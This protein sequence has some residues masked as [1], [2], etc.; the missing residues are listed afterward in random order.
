MISTPTLWGPGAGTANV[1]AIGLPVTTKEFD[2]MHARHFSPAIVGRRYEDVMVVPGRRQV[3][4]NISIPVTPDA[5]GFWLLMTLG[6]D[7][8]TATTGNAGACVLNAGI[9]ANATSMVI[10]SL[11]NNLTA[12][13]RIFFRDTTTVG[14]IGTNPEYATV[15]ANATAGSSVTVTITGGAGTGG[16]VKNAHAISTLVEFG[17]WTHTFTPVN[18]PAGT[19]SFQVEDNEGGIAVSKFFTGMVVDSMDISAPIEKDGDPLVATI[20]AIGTSINPSGTQTNTVNTVASPN[21]AG[22]FTLP[23]EEVP[24]VPGNFATFTSGQTTK[25]DA[26]NLNPVTAGGVAGKVYV[27]D[28]KVTLSNKAQLAKAQNSSPDPYAAIF[29]NFSCKG[30]MESLFEDYSVFYD[31]VKTNV[32]PNSQLVVNWGVQNLTSTTGAVASTLTLNIFNFAMEKTGKA[33]SKSELVYFPID[34]WRAVDTSSVG[35]QNFTTLMSAVL[36]NNVAVY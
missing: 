8:V 30:T 6:A 2:P 35:T 12:G 19:P 26:T 7:A 4:A 23:T 14:G 15:A 1:N 22:A 20:K 32:W 5:F 28:F 24:V 31:Y 9:S 33:A 10:T 25:V 3:Q 17:P 18:T 13:Q 27:P 21:V 36:V 34:S 11:A 16:G 29:T